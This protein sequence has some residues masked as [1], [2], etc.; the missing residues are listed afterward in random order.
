VSIGPSLAHDMPRSCACCDGWHGG[1]E[2]EPLS[3]PWGMCVAR[4]RDQYLAHGT[5]SAPASL[6]VNLKQLGA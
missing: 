6:D 2:G 5:R 3:E 1:A 4:D